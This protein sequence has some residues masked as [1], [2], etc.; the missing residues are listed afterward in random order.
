MTPG[1]SFTQEQSS[2]KETKES[3]TIRVEGNRYDGF[4]IF[5]GTT[6]VGQMDIIFD[7]RDKTL[8]IQRIIIRSECTIT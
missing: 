7:D 2:P 1:K 4:T 8:R 6:K 3:L 5:S